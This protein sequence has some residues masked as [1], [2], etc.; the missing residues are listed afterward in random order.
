MGFKQA[1]AQILK[2]LRE[3]RVQHEARSAQDQTNL[4]AIGAVST[5]EAISIIQQ[6]R[7]DQAEPRPLHADPSITVWI[8]K[9]AGWY[10]KFYFLDTAWFVSFHPPR[11]R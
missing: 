8:L 5:V 4:L 10:I 3:G 2:A 11:V 9:P 6:T 1:K 7:G